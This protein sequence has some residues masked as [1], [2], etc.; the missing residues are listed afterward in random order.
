MIVDSTDTRLKD[1]MQANEIE[2]GKQYR[3]KVNNNLVIVKVDD[4][5]ENYAGKKRY[6]VTNLTTNRTTVFKSAAKFRSR[7]VPE[8][9]RYELGYMQGRGAS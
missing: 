4:I 2:V 8:N 9:D 7:Y 5:T 1:I 3:A 6:H